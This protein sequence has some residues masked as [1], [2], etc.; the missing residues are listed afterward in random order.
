[1]PGKTRI[2]FKLFSLMEK[3]STPN[4]ITAWSKQSFKK[5]K[6]DTN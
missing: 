1:M 6:W 2:T 4:S 3:L 5:E